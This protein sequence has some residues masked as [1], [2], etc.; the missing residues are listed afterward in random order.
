M[1]AVIPKTEASD[2]ESR[3]RNGGNLT[4]FEGVIASE[5]NRPT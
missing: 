1:R 4:S 3:R 5:T 2:E